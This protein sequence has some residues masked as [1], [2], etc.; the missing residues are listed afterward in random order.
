MNKKLLLFSHIIILIHFYDIRSQEI[1]VS[2]NPKKI[3]LGGQLKISLNIENEQIKSYGKFPEI[4]GFSKTGISSSSSTNFINGKRSS[5]QSIIQNY[6]AKETGIFNIPDFNIKVNNKDVLV[7]GTIIEVDDSYDEPKQSP[8][9]NFFDPFDDPFDNFFERNNNEFYEVE[10]DAFLS[11]NTDKKSVYIGEAFNTTL[12]FFVSENN[13]ADMRFYELGRQLTEI[14]KKIKPPNCWEENFNIENINS[15][16][17]IINNKRYNQYKIFEATYY[18]F[19]NEKIYFPELELELIKYKVSKRP[20]FFGRNKIEDYEKFNSNPVEVKV[21]DLPDHP[22]K[23]K[24]V[25]GNFKLRE[26]I[27]KQELKTGE[28]FNYDFEIVGEGNISS[29]KEPEINK[30]SIEFYSPNSQQIINREKS[31][32]FGSKKFSYYAIP[33]IPGDYNLSDNIYWIYFNSN[34]KNYDTLKT[35]MKLLVTGETKNGIN[36]NNSEISSIIKLIKSKPN[37]LKSYKKQV[38]ISIFLNIIILT[39]MLI[40]SLYLI[41]SRK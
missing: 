1:T 4:D 39:L 17:V 21:I 37:N 33:N 38:D 26:K 24:V 22:L 15:I 16:P 31:K 30:N 20:S 10:A 14:I 41:F 8:F 28:G 5:S 25:V 36:K 29:I 7:S 40:S 18:P 13:V 35:N 23:D 9:N 3:S 6:I 19:N 12:S 32:V 11:L 34:K 27:N 2:I